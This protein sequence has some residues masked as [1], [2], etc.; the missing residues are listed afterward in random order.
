ML[1]RGMERSK[2]AACGA[3]IM[4]FFS[5]HTVFAA[6]A[7][8]CASART[9]IKLDFKTLTAATAYNH[10]LTL[11]GIANLS[12]AQGGQIAGGGRPVGL[13]L[14]NTLYGVGGEVALEP[15]GSGFCVRLT[16]VKI[17]FGW[18]RMDVYV[19]TEFPEGSCE[20]RAVRDHENQHVSIFRTSL[21]EFAPRARARIEAVLARAKPFPVRSRNGA[22]QTALAPV[23]AE[24]AALQQE[25]NAL[26]GARNARID[27][28]SN[29]A[30]VTALC[31]NW[32]GTGAR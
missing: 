23:N 24:L 9:P 16:S 7:P 32:D 4:L 12:R 8:A 28:P 14:A 22:V 10:H 15:Q 1:A 2:R 25:F 18:D 21:A 3:L 20:Y 6:A 5:A 30:A 31:N 19:P 26:H 13:T 27:T 11:G 17:D 29:Y